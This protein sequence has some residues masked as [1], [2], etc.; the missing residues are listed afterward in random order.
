VACVRAWPKR[1]WWHGV[2]RRRPET[3][4]TGAAGL[5]TKAPAS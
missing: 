4:I 3:T 1:Y 5:E 2:R